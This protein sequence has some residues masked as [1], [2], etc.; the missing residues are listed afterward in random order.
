[1]ILARMSR[2]CYRH[3]RRVVFLWVVAFVVLNAIGGTV[4][5]AYSDNF[6]GYKSDSI[7][8]FDLLQERF[9]ERAGD[10]ADIVF[11][12]EQGVQDPDVRVRVEELLA[13]VGPGEV[14]D[15]VLQIEL[16]GP[17]VARALEESQSAS[18]YIGLLAAVV[19]LFI[20][21]GS[22]LAMSLPIVAAVV[23]VGIG[24]VLVTLLSHAIPVP[25]FAPYLAG[26]I[27]LGVGIDYA[28]FI[29]VRYRSGLHDGLDP[30]DANVLA[31][32]TAG[33]AVLF[34]GSTVLVSLLGMFM[35]GVDFYYGLSLGA[36]AAVLMTMLASVTLV[37][38]IM[39][40]AG[41]KLAAKE[42]KRVHH[43]ET[44]AFRWSRQIQRRPWLMAS[45]SLAVL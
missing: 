36:M 42:H 43:R 32:T 44:A 20:A 8:A 16:S 18:E 26:M 23:G 2:W 41:S 38:A 1:M 21:F 25:S 37:P 9:P 3:R 10:T 4:G 35:L 29:V 33:R 28:L 17:V 45:V 22:L 15:A 27:G 31:L 19:I 6:S 30:E 39:G 13:A 40:F 5:D 7:E 24:S 12:A 14:D 11:K 34:A